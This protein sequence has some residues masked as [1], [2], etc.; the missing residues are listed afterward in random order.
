M[1]KAIAILLFLACTDTDRSRRILYEEGYTNIVM[2]GHAW[3]GCHRDDQYCTA[4]HATGPK[5]DYV[6]GVVGC[7]PQS[8]DSSCTVRIK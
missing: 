2:E 7:G 4:F 1:K 6:E 8:C 5:G 3:M